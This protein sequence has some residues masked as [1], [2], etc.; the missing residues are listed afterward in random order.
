MSADTT[1]DVT[2][3][4]VPDW[5]QAE[6]FV[7]V[8]KES[9]KGFS[10]IKSFKVSNGVAAGENYATIMLRVNFEIELDGYATA[11]SAL[12][13]VLLDRTEAA[14]VEKILSDSAEGNDSKTF[15][16]SNAR[17]RKHI[18]VILPWLYNRGAMEY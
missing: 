7:D 11:T 17:Y 4:K 18:Q 1:T 13:A 8:L 2:T 16:Y 12:S 10:K 5:V 3:S 9:V 15:L 6:Q 14:S